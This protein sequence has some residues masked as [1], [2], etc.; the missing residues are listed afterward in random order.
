VHFQ[1]H[2]VGCCAFKD[3]VAHGVS[4]VLSAEGLQYSYF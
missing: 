1:A 2:P 3:G 4:F